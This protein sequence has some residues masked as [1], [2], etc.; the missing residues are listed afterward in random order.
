MKRPGCKTK[1]LNHFGG[2]FLR[3]PANLAELAFVRRRRVLRR[4]P[5]PQVGRSHVG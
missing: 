4:P 3:I 2:L 5:F 1:I